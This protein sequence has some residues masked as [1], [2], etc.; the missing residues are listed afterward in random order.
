MR[1][2]RKV[3][4]RRV[5]RAGAKGF[6]L[7][8]LMVAIVVAGIVLMGIFAFS[9]I[10]QGTAVQ[11]RRHVRVQQALEGS[12]H[13]M[14]RDI[15]MAGLGF[16]RTCSE[17]RIWDP[18]N[19]GRLINP[20][21]T[22]RADLASVPVDQM[23][24]EPFWV[25]RDGIQV[26][27]R[28]SQENGSGNTI[29]GTEGTSASPSSAADAFDVMLGER[30]YTSG[31]GMFVADFSDGLP[32][33]AADATLDFDSSDALDMGDGNDVAAMQQLFPPGS[34]VLLVN[35]ASATE[36]VDFT[37][38]TQTQCVLLQVTGELTTD[39]NLWNL[40]IGNASGFNQDLAALFTTGAL[41]MPN[42]ANGSEPGHDWPETAMAGSVSVVPL[43]RFR[44]SRYEIDYTM[45]TRPY[46]VR[47]DIIG[48][49]PDTDVEIPVNIADSYPGCPDDQCQ[50]PQLH[51]PTNDAS[52]VPRTAIG[53]MIEDMQVA[54]GCDGWDPNNLPDDIPVPDPGF[55]EK[56]PNTNGQVQGDGEPNKAVDERT[57]SDDRGNDEWVGNAVDEQWAPDCVYFG[58]GERWALDW[59]GAG[60]PSEIGNAPGFRLAPQ[61]LRVTLVGKPETMASAGLDI[62]DPFYTELAAI[63]DRPVI[64]AVVT[65]REYQ[66]L[67]E[68]F[69]PR[70]IR[71]RDPGFL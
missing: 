34:F 40:P 49:D 47:S 3:V 57:I 7:I 23:T 2:E 56:G 62:T 53:P 17:V 15:R 20:G 36:S 44:W 51:L 6:S 19:G 31:A 30:N 64:D 27:W 38:Q 68:R 25:L 4:G 10:Q 21:A 5:R 66:V 45:P 41:G 14:A 42:D 12:M 18:S 32:V 24:G 67:T 35:M 50:M 33:T 9:S 71:W 60:P 46:L 55:E 43:G 48:F 69:S 13:S 29:D 16:G 70:N 37:P 58:T 59:A 26:F 39:T 1:V 28:S 52:A 61:M 65:G 63:E 8:E 22:N 54:V 11:H